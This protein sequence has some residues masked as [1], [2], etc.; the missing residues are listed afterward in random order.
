MFEPRVLLRGR[1]SCSSGVLAPYSTAWDRETSEGYEDQTQ[2]P[3]TRLAER[4]LTV[5]ESLRAQGRSILWFLEQVI[6]ARLTGAT[7]YS[8]LPSAR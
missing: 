3:G 4:M 8:L 7:S 6:R 5:S 1:R 2:Q